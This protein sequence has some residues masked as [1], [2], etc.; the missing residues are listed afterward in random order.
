MPD[1]ALPPITVEAYG[2]V[3]YPPGLGPEDVARLVAEA[4]ATRTPSLTE[5]P[6]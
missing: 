2:L 6:S 4:D 3:S 5:E 1:M